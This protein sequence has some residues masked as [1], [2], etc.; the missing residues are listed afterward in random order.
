MNDRFKFRVFD[1]TA[2]K[3][4]PRSQCVL[5]S[6]STLIQQLAGED[7]ILEDT[8][9]EQCTGSKDK[10]G[11]LI[12]E[13]DI[14]RYVKHSNLGLGGDRYAKVFWW[15]TVQGFAIETNYGDYYGLDDF[16]IEVVGNIHENGDLLK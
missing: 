7:I 2:K 5:L 3:Y 1:N 8:I 6:D 11:N 16:E 9:I 15:D 12:Y 10:K 4:L 13:S 14:I